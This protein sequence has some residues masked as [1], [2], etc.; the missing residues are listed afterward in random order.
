MA[1]SETRRQLILEA[2]VRVVGR[3]GYKA[4][5]V[6]DVIE[7]ADVSRTTFYKH[8]DD[9]HECF[10]AAYDL[11]VDRVLGEVVAK[12]DA[13]QPWLERMRVGLATVVEMFALDPELAR[14][15]IVEV[16]AA[17]AEARQR[18]WD[19]VSRL[20]V[21]LAEGEELAG[22]RELPPNIGLMAAG[23]VSGLIFD[24]LL[25]GRAERLP[26]LLPDLLFAMLVP[27]IGPGAATEEM[28]RA[29][30]G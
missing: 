10:L 24:E 9:K 15:A 1:G 13:G 11:V 28:R 2:M 26:E 7:E 8:F 19:A 30:A 29:A 5:S 21:Y 6:A 16:A 18:H 12:C 25:T 22:G 23:A 17:G 14:T 3:K 4:T 27:Y 20:T